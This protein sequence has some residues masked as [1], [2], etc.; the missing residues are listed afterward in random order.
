MRDLMKDLSRKKSSGIIKKKEAELRKAQQQSAVVSCIAQQITAKKSIQSAKAIQEQVEKL[1]GL[2]V[3][4]KTVLGTLKGHFKLSYRKVKKVSYSGNSEYNRVRRFL[5][6]QK[7]LELYSQGQHV[8]NVDESWLPESDFSRKNW[9]K[10]GDSHSIPA[11]PLGRKINM[12]AAVSSEGYVWLALTQPN[13]DED[14]MRVFL[15][16]LA[17]IFTKQFGTEWRERIVLLLD[18]ASYHRSG[19]TRTCIQHLQ[20]K[21]VLSAP[22]SYAAAPAELFFAHFKRGEFNPD[23]IPTGKL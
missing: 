20:M 15:S 7:M 3:S 16:K 23:R 9:D 14:V 2:Q 17:L 12:I 5:Y 13:T 8:V 19:E 22:Y 4:T 18:G 11:N 1:S 6:A 21:V 10:R